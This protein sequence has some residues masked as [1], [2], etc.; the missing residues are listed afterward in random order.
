ML[1]FSIYERDINMK[2]YNLGILQ[3]DNPNE[4]N[5]WYVYDYDE[6]DVLNNEWFETEGDAQ[7][8]LDAFLFEHGTDDDNGMGD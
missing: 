6:E 3:E 2:L 7:A 5:T 4:V 1:L 8:Y